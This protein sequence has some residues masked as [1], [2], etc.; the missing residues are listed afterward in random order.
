MRQKVIAAV[1]CAAMLLTFSACGSKEDGSAVGETT[2]SSQMAPDT[3]SDETAAD[4]GYVSQ[5]RAFKINGEE[6]VTKLCDYEN[7]PKI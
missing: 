6:Y 5:S 2:E 7:I 1:L 3:G 4:S